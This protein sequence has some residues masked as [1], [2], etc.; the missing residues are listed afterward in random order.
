MRGGRTRLVYS[1]LLT[2]IALNIAA[3]IPAKNIE[4]STAVPIPIS[5]GIASSPVA[6]E[7]IPVPASVRTKG[8]E[9]IVNAFATAILSFPPFHG[10]FL[11]DQ[12]HRHNSQ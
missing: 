7:M 2:L 4:I 1:S 3:K 11:D 10:L 8:S 9:V 6:G 12:I 5:G